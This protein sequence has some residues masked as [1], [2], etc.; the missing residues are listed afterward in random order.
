MHGQWHMCY[1]VRFMVFYFSFKH[2][3]IDARTLEETT[4]VSEKHL[5]SKKLPQSSTFNFD[6]SAEYVDKCT[7]DLLEKNKKFKEELG[8]FDTKLE[9]H[10]K[11]T[12]AT[13]TQLCTKCSAVMNPNDSH[14]NIRV[15]DE[16]TDS[17]T[18][19][20]MDF[21]KVGKPQTDS[22]MQCHWGIDINKCLQ[23]KVNSLFSPPWY[24]APCGYQLQLLLYPNGYGHCMGT[25]ASIFLT[26]VRGA[27]D[28]RLSWPVT[29]TF[30]MVILD[31]YHN[32]RPIVKTFQLSCS[33]NK[34][35]QNT[36]QN[37]IVATG[38]SEFISKEIILN[39]RYVENGI[40]RLEFKFNPSCLQ[41]I[42]S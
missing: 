16:H 38:C 18:T 36:T 6:D 2:N 31:L 23:R 21:S 10:S 11:R 7:S 30:S 8:D 34:P 17:Y 40:I 24:N 15:K 41:Q 26:I 1:G 12:N 4:G 25:H 14:H 13:F 39:K 35:E 5:T 29:G 32:A 37:T 42:L 19:D 33:F 3:Q 28:G 27:H 9:L 20:F 22:C